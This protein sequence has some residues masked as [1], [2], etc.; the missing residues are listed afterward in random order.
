VQ[1]KGRGIDVI[2]T[3]PQAIHTAARV[4]PQLVYQP[5]LEA[6]IAGSDAIVLLT[7]WK[8]YR[9]LDPWWVGSLVNSR[10]I[11][12]G[13]NCLNAEAW[14]AAGWTV[15]GMGRPTMLAARELVSF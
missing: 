6:A 4:H 15:I 7:E 11:I 10:V 12:D 3:D 13:R 9:E 1:L 2:A 14:A 5:D 8:L